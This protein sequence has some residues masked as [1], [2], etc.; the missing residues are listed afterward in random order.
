MLLPRAT[1]AATLRV[2]VTD[3]CNLRCAYCMPEEGVPLVP[4]GEIPSL[5][6]L[7][8]AVAWLVAKYGVDRVKV[9][10]GEPLVRGGV[11]EFVAKVAAFPGVSEVSMTTNGTR[12]VGT[13]AELARAGLARVNIS[14]DTVDPDRFR[15]LTRG[16]RVEEVL[17]GID[18]AL[19]AGLTPLKLNSVLRRS[20][21]QGDVPALLDLA[22]GKGIEIR[23]IELMQTG[24]EAAWAIA[25]RV[26]GAEVRAWLTAEGAEIA[27]LPA[28][29]NAPA[30]RTVISW[31]GRDVMAGWIDPV[32]HS[33]CDDCDRLRLDARGRLRRCLM[34]DHAFPL[35][36]LLR[37]GEADV[38]AAAASYVAGKQ[39]PTAMTIGSTMASIGG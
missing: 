26:S 30:R 22:A 13:A 2:S 20:S 19:D 29:P 38:A 4:R 33:F 23:F 34:D 28:R 5:T 14:L 16:G 1:G 35:V 8:S 10:G 37:R 3:R 6:E 7:A 9:T 32:S 17:A 12:L 11:P 18:A 31:K 25:E 27:P 21:F 39:P 24:T 15:E 36:D